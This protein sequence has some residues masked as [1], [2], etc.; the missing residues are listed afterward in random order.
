MV[1]SSWLEDWMAERPLLI[2]LGTGIHISS[3]VGTN[4]PNAA[5]NFEAL[6][7]LPTSQAT[8]NLVSGLIPSVR[9]QPTTPEVRTA[10]PWLETVL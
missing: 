10:A 1:S 8:V 9:V 7:P 5:E 6:P 3:P 4:E 2:I